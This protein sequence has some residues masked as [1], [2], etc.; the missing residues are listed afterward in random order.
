MKITK[1]LHSCLLVEDQGKSILT[2]P[3]SYTHNDKALDIN[4]LQKLDFI[5][6]TH[7]HQ[8]HMHIPFIKELLFKFPNVKIITNDSVAKILEKENIPS[9]IEN[10][11]FIKSMK[12]PHEK[13]FMGPVPANILL[14]L[15]G[16]VTHPG[17]SLSF[18]KTSKILALPITAPWGSTT[19]AVEKALELKPEIIIPIHDWHWKDTARKMFYDVLENYFGQFNIKFEKLETGTTIEV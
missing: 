15:F 11:E 13:I 9:Q 4:T 1:Y 19:W 18:N 12:V 7:E 6:I 5:A 2:D 14:T 17:D 16:K 3:G 8:D 10:N